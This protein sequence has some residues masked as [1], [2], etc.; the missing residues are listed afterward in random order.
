MQL[1]LMR[2]PFSRTSVL[3]IKTSHVAMLLVLLVMFAGSFLAAGLYLA[4]R[5][6]EQIPVVQDIVYSQQLA[7][8]HDVAETG[9]PLDAMAIRLA[10]MRAQ[11]AR[12]DAVSVRL[13]KSNGLDTKVTLTEQLGQGGLQQKD[14][15]SLNYREVK[16]AISDVASQIERQADVFSIIDTDLQSARVKFL[17][18]PN[19]SPLS[20]TIAVSNFGNRIDP[21]TGRRSVHE[22]IDFIAPTGT[23]ILAAA[24]GVVVEAKWHPGYGNMVEIEHNNKTT[25]RY[26]HASKLLVK[27]G[28]QSRRHCAA[29]SKNCLGRQYWPLNWP[30][31]ALRSACRRRATKPQQVSGKERSSPSWSLNCSRL[32]RLILGKRCCPSGLSFAC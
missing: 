17:S 23:P 26:G 16:T 11:L 6:G 31:L 12:L 27:A 9:S 2:G 21:F 15:K 18:V 32:K 20:D 28:T 10:E 1:I 13:L 14:E 4:A 25:T 29:R 3:S 24:A 7:K 19:E 22:G 30:S 8:H 5:Y